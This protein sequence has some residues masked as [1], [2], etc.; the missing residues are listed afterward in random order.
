MNPHMFDGIVPVIVV[1]L[2]STAILAVLVVVAC[3]WALVHF[4]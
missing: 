2:V 4:L 1:G 3:V